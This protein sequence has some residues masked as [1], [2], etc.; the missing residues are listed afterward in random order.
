M[1]MFPANS[2]HKAIFEKLNTHAPLT[3]AVSGIYDRVAPGAIF[4]Y[5]VLDAVDVTPWDTLTLRGYRCDIAV[6]IFSRQGGRK[7]L[8]QIIDIIYALLHNQSLS[9]ALF[10]TAQM[11]VIRQQTQYEADTITSSAR[12]T[13]RCYIQE[14]EV[15]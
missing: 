5:V 2:F 6:D 12:L 15:V 11:Q 13:V 3:L 4:P 8:T 10:T 1:S 14:L 7:E 9:V